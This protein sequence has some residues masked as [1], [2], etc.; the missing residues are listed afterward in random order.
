MEMDFSFLEKGMKNLYYLG[1]D[2]EEPS[3]RPEDKGRD[4][5]LPSIETD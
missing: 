5:P 3:N 4:D 1:E 2:E